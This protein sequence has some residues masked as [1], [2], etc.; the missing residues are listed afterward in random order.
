MNFYSRH[1]KF[2]WL[3]FPLL[4]IVTFG[5]TVVFQNQPAFTEKFYSQWVYPPFARGLSF[6]S[7]LFAFSVSDVFYVFL[8]LLLLALFVFLALRKISFVK[9]LKLLVSGLSL[10]YFLFYVLWGFN[11]FRSN[12]YER[13]GISDVDPGNDAFIETFNRLVEN[14]NAHAN[15]INKVDENVIDSLVEEAYKKSAGA[16][17]LKYP[18]GQR[19]DKKITFS[20]FFAK[21]TISGYYGPFFNEVHVNRKIH[22][23]EYPF[24][25][26][27]EKAHQF[28]ITSEAEANFFACL[29]CA[30]SNSEILKY[31]ADLALLRFFIFQGYQLEE[32]SDIIAKLD[33]KPK[34]DFNIIR[35]HWRNLRNKK[36]DKAAAKANDAYLKANKIEKGIYDYDGVVKHFV[37][38]SLDSAFQKKYELK[39]W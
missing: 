36:I 3:V 27:H 9:S 15:G 11:Y 18:M 1:K 26:A 33:E 29:A 13:T 7:N 30:Q 39:A 20:R 23:L 6:F 32:F 17:N 4:A 24:V 25:L 10:L 35:E 14:L 37:N 8:F 5:I 31:S 2:L 22:P 34:N 16:L 28:G 21:A 19:N 12:L 38:F